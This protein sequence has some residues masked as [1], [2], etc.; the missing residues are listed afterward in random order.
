MFLTIS[1]GMVW[2]GCSTLSRGKQGEA[3]KAEGGEAR[4]YRAQYHSFDDVLVPEELKYDQKASFVYETPQFKAGALVFS[5]WRLDVEPLINFF[6]YHME[7]DN[8][9]LV[10]TY[11]GKESFLNFTKPDRTCTIRIIEKWYGSTEVEIRVGPVGVAKTETSGT[12]AVPN[13]VAK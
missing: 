12:E 5:K 4:K 9:R 13:P 2:M 7:R 6:T 3:G 8:W 1:L 10:N 11:K